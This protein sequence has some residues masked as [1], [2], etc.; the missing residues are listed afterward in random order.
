M[1]V[2]LIGVGHSGKPIL[3]QQQIPNRYPPNSYYGQPGPMSYP[4]QSHILSVSHRSVSQGTTPN[5]SIVPTSVSSNSAIN[6]SN[7]I[8]SVPLKLDDSFDD[9]SKLQA[10]QS[11]QQIMFHPLSQSCSR[12]QSTSYYP[13]MAPTNNPYYPSQH[14]TSASP[15]YNMNMG[16]G[17]RL[18]PVPS[19]AYGTLSVQQ[20]IF[21]PPATNDHTAGI[22]NNATGLLPGQPPSSL[23]H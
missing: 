3:S 4:H 10:S 21:V 9:P 6:K 23:T 2:S 11:Q 8:D 7:F 15:D 16:R 5:Y 1:D 12:P 14:P 22:N 20:R 19:N 13:N 18:T 17:I